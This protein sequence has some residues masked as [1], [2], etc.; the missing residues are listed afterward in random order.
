[1]PLLLRLVLILCIGIIARY[2]ESSPI[3][4]EEILIADPE[5][6]ETVDILIEVLRDGR[7]RTEHTF[8]LRVTG[9]TIR[10]GPVLNY[11]TAFRGPG[12]LI[13]DRGLVV[14]E[15]LRNGVPEPFRTINEQGYLQ[16]TIGSS[17]VF[18]ENKTHEYTI[19]STSRGD[20]R[21][22]DG[23][24]MANLDV[25]GPL[26]RY[27]IDSARVRF[28]LPDGV[29]LDRHTVALR[30]ATGRLIPHDVSQTTTELVVEVDESLGSGS[31]FFINAVW[32]SAGFTG[33]SHWLEILKQHPKLPLTAF[34]ALL[35]ICAL[36]ILL[37]RGRQKA[38]K[39]PEL[40]PT[41]G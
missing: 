38:G 20:W 10:R 30:T 8:G 21:Y 37:G 41:A 2:G 39:T 33:K 14:K 4:S 6:I 35:L 13:L 32:P 36:V 5:S 31:A 34:I 22:D 25:L 19:R 28:R 7:V 1:M 23:F 40:V 18:I 24:A 29:A 11:L 15:V 27:P 3:P 17:D 9:R 16:L 26:H 12:G